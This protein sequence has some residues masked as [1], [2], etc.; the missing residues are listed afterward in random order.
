MRRDR[1]SKTTN[2]RKAV[3]NAA[4]ELLASA[5]DVVRGSPRT[6]LQADRMPYIVVRVISD[7]VDG[8]PTMRGEV[9]VIME[10]TVN[11]VSSE[12]EDQ[13]DDLLTECDGLLFAD[14]TLGGAVESLRYDNFELDDPEIEGD[15]PVFS[16][17][18]TYLARTRR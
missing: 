1:S 7:E 10:L 15:K 9:S 3:R 13:I 4:A 17:T 5:G 12:S 2:Y 8:D 6:V 18:A 11:V 14:Q 16:G